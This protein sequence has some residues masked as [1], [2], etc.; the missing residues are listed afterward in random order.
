MVRRMLQPTA[1]GPDPPGCLTIVAVFLAIMAPLYLLFRFFVRL[2][3]QAYGF[4]SPG[5][6]EGP[7]LRV[8]FGCNNTVLEADFAH[9]PYCGAELPADAAAAGPAPAA[10]VSDADPAL[11]GEVSS[12]DAD[13]E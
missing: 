3:R 2:V 13:A 5:A 11:P 6:D 10:D 1:G 4:D 8:C 12:S 9:C 7:P